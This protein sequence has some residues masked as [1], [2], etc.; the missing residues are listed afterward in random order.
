[1]DETYGTYV[2]DAC[3]CNHDYD[4]TDH[5]TDDDFDDD[6]GID[7]NDDTDDYTDDRRRRKLFT[8]KAQGSRLNAQDSRVKVQGSM[9]KGSNTKVKDQEPCLAMKE[10]PRRDTDVILTVEGSNRALQF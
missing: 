10:H 1:M 2:D 3:F 8:I 5:D 6:T 7:T 4:D 9:L